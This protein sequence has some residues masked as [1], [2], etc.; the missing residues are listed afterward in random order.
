M[1]T[2]D[3]LDVGTAT[4]ELEDGRASEAIAGGGEMGEVGAAVL[5]EHVERGGEAGAEER[6]VLLVLT[7]FLS[8][9][10][11]LWAHALTIDICD[12]HIVAEFSQ[13]AGG[14]LLVSADTGPLVD[15]EDCRAFA[16]E[17]I[18]IGLP[19]FADDLSG[20]ILHGFFDDGRAER[21]EKGDGGEGSAAETGQHGGG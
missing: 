10:R 19:A 8:G 21:A 2:H 9:R 17:C 16:R 6:A 5:L 3:A 12:E 1:E 4:G 11:W 15:D 14:F 13:L 20:F 7:S 18:V